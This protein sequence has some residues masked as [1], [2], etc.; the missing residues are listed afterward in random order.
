MTFW[1]S[2]ALVPLFVEE[3]RSRACRDLVRAD[4]SMYVWA[5]TWV[6]V[7]SA[8]RRIERTGQIGAAA[9]GA[10]VARLERMREHWTEVTPVNVVAERAIRLLAVH[11]LTAADA[12][13]LA[14][15]IELVGDRPRKHRFVTADA[16]LADAA[17]RSGFDVRIP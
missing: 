11:S 13:Q 14:A 4:R 6:E 3:A 5:L 10:A 2:S 17:A 1:D 9:A 7:A 16:A 15:A 12:L 8:L